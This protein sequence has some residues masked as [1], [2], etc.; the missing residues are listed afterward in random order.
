M[1]DEDGVVDV[2]LAGGPRGGGSVGELDEPPRSSSTDGGA[3][4][5]KSFTTIINPNEFVSVSVGDERSSAAP[6]SSKKLAS[7][8]IHIPHPENFEQYVAEAF[9]AEQRLC[10]FLCPKGV[11]ISRGNLSPKATIDIS[12]KIS[13]YTDV[14]IE[15]LLQM[16]ELQF[17]KDYI[18][19]LT[20]EMPAELVKK[21]EAKIKTLKKNDPA[22]KAALLE[23][24][25]RL[26]HFLELTFRALNDEY[27]GR[28]VRRNGGVV[29]EMVSPVAR[30]LEESLQGKLKAHINC[31]LI[32]KIF[33]PCFLE[34]KSAVPR[35]HWYHT[36]AALIAMIAVLGFLL[37]LA[38]HF[39]PVVG[40][41]ISIFL[42][43]AQL[44]LFVNM[45][46]PAFSLGVVGAASAVSA[47]SFF[48]RKDVVQ[49]AAIDSSSVGLAPGARLSNV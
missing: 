23:I 11:A 15:N 14:R 20:E 27:Q 33:T 7:L 16:A 47:L 2:D 34:A 49:V 10:G 5:P 37:G 8:F 21:L 19:R 42:E 17:M 35:P 31:W 22:L 40:D 36:R 9:I 26:N 18:T 4:N 43:P 28:A 6:K 29:M 38:V 25:V 13:S 12:Q 3:A 46:L 48:P 44:A 30:I 39:I 24:C 41:G 32:D 45:I 1:A